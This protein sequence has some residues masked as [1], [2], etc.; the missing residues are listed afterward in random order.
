MTHRSIKLLIAAGLVTALGSQVGW[1]PDG[2][3]L[4]PATASEQGDD[5]G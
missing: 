4:S 2:L 1:L 3:S 5:H